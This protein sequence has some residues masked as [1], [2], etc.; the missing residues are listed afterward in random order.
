MNKLIVD[1]KVLSKINENQRICTTNP[2]N[3]TIEKNNYSQAIRRYY[4]GDSRERAIQSID[5]LINQISE[6]SKNIFNSS[7][8]NL[9]D[10]VENPSKHEIEEHNK[11]CSKLKNLSKEITN[12]IN[13]ITNLQTTY[14]D[15][16]IT[17]SRL[18]MI[19]QNLDSLISEIE[20]KLEQVKLKKK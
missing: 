5:N 3:L 16:A 7:T 15:D 17:T 4:F 18:D 14:N 13:G 20:K 10:L 11:E 8:L 2:D 9:Y 6:Y 19:L 1:L 12:A